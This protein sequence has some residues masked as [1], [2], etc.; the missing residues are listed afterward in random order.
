MSKIPRVSGLF[1]HKSSTRE[2]LSPQKFARIELHSLTLIMGVE[3]FAGIPREIHGNFHSKV[4]TPG[5]ATHQAGSI[6]AGLTSFAEAIRW[7]AL[8]LCSFA[9]D[10]LIPP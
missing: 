1:P 9:M 3:L 2:S 7:G 5:G 8:S 10:P 6:E 4:D